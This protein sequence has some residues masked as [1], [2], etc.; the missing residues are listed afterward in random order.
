MTGGYNCSQVLL[1]SEAI[2]ACSHY[3]LTSYPK[4]NQE[5]NRS[6]VV[7]KLEEATEL[8]DIVYEY[9]NR[10][11]ALVHV[12]FQDLTIQRYINHKAF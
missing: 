9:S 4:Q 10:N 8:N 12:Y 3:V 1:H 6:Y 2:A 5:S 11:V 7:A